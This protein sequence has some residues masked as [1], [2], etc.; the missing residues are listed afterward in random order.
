MKEDEERKELEEL[1]VAILNLKEEDREKLRRILTQYPKQ[2]VILA[3]H[4][5][6][7][8]TKYGKSRPIVTIDEFEKIVKRTRF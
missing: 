5:A 7:T 6:Y 8:V 2:K 1:V 4:N 3:L